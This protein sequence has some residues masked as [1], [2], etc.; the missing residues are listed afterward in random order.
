MDNLASMP[1]DTKNLVESVF[2]I[3]WVTVI[4]IVFMFAIPGCIISCYESRST[5]Q[6]EILAHIPSHLLEDAVRSL[7][8][9]EGVKYP[10]FLIHDKDGE[11]QSDEEEEHIVRL[12]GPLICMMFGHMFQ[13]IQR[14]IWTTHRNTSGKVSNTSSGRETREDSKRFRSREFS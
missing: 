14:W 11:E 4:F 2:M 10:E 13:I 9:N 1:K 8:A 3:S 6:L 5:T 7:C 12:R